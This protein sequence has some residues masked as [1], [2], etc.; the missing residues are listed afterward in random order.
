MATYCWPQPQHDHSHEPDENV[1]VTYTELIVNSGSAVQ[2][3]DVISFMLG[4]VRLDGIL[5][6]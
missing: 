5:V 6:G 4:N 3:G 1:G 2:S